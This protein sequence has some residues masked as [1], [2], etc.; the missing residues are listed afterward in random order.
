MPS[1]RRWFQSVILLLGLVVV[2]TALADIA[3]GPSVLPGVVEA[4][5]TLDSNY[6]FFAGLWCTLGIVMLAT[7]PHVERHALALRAVFGAV[8]LGGLARGLSYLSVGAPHA[9]F[10][11][12]IGVE[13]LLPPLL[14][15]W[16]R[17]VC[18]EPARPGTR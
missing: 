14:L 10:T 3:L 18:R 13:L 8:F 2:G 15:L 5:T 11:A 16:S 9:L 4:D 17:R 7:V 12:G 1:S 6:R